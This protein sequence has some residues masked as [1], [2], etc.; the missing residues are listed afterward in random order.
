MNDNLNKIKTLDKE[1]IANTYARYDVAFKSGH[2]TILY[3]YDGMKY[4]DFTSGIGVNS[5]GIGDKL[6]KKAVTEQMNMVT[7]V[8]NLYYTSPQ[9]KLAEMLCERTGMKK[10][11][12]GNSGAEA[13][14]GAI[15]CARK[16]SFDK[17]GDN[18]YE[19]I[20]LV[21]S[22]HGRTIATLTATGQDVFHQYFGPF[23]DGFVYAKPNDINDLKSKITSKTCA[24]MIETVQG[25]G[26]VMPLDKKYVKELANI[27]EAQD[28]L[29]IIDEVQTGNGRT[30]YLYS[31]EGYNI[32]PNIVTTAKGLCGGL[33][34]GAVL[35][36]EKTQ[37]T[38]KSGDHGTTF[39]G[40]PICCNASLSILSRIDDNLL[41]DIQKK[42]KYIFKT[43]KEFKNVL[44]IS[45]MG[46]MIGLETNK[47][48]REIAAECLKR[49][50]VVLTA[51]NKVRLL[52][53]LNI[54]NKNLKE[55]LMILKEVIEQ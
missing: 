32:K 36:D 22:F 7:H 21:N 26:G 51:K 41:N 37:F 48:A 31:Y 11:F 29:I 19:I 23:V 54:S 2:G 12:F 53:A 40:N 4:I 44:S 16:Y 13:N 27:A 35:F 1:Y 47:N 50:L 46:L 52:P 6:W 14:E 42:S 20:T 39:G 49:G 55:G 3:D 30:G 38:L 10:V 5:F 33:P 25:E 8:S 43:I 18:R 28:I 34:L 45:G 24:I 9:T 17:Y 15:K